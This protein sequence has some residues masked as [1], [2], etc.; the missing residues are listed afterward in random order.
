[1]PIVQVQPVTISQYAATFSG[2]ILTAH[3]LILGFIS[4]HRPDYSRVFISDRHGRFI[5]H[6]K[7]PARLGVPESFQLWASY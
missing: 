7:P 2:K 6:R 3:Y 5:V 4:Q 1:V